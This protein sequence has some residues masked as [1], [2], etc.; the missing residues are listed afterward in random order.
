MAHPQ[1][2]IP[3]ERQPRGQILL[4]D[5]ES[6]FTSLAQDIL[7]ARGWEVVCARSGFEALQLAS[8]QSFDAVLLDLRMPLLSGQEV[9]DRIRR[10]DPTVPVIIIT[11]AGDTPIAVQCMRQGAFDY[12]EKPV[13]WDRL[14]RCLENACRAR[15]LEVQVEDLRKTLL[16]RYGFDWLIGRSKKIQEVFEAIQRVC[17]TDVTVL[18]Q[19]E[20]GTGKELV[21]RAI[22]FNSPRRAKPFVAVNCAA[23][24]ETLLESELFG[25]ERGS[26]TG[27]VGRR[28]GRF[29]QAN[30]GTLFLDEIGEMTPATQVKILRV[31][32]ERRFERLGG[33]RPVEVDVRIISAT[34]KDLAEE[35]RRGNF[36]QDLYYRI[37]VYPIYLPPLRERKEDIPVL[38]GFFLERF[39]RRMPPHRRVRAV[40][41]ETLDCLM[42]Y[43]WPGNVRELENVIERS[44]LHVN[45]GVLR[46]VHLP[47]AVRA[48]EASGIRLQSSWREALGNC[49]HIPRWREV[50][51]ELLKLA[52]RLTKNNVTAAAAKLGIGRTTLYRKIRK[53]RI[54]TPSS[55][56][57]GSPEE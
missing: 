40:A 3:A 51:E 29:E 48:P 47:A 32:Q 2:V 33:T 36:R 38:V 43:P 24:P 18:V 23:I 53:Y 37:C 52:L 12:F 30:G 45:D 55:G 7:Q 25:H 19:G 10:L 54:S 21:A 50:E 39:N 5:D 4:V 56:A 26:F 1:V 28:I 42:Q 27:A 6:E 41:S 20:S 16:Q 8:L 57:G 11:G 13:D 15:L 46:P 22:H 14:Q 49:D 17:E 34:N 31:L 44:M 35:V 9:L